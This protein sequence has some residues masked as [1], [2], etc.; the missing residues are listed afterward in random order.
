MARSLQAGWVFLRTAWCLAVIPPVLLGYCLA[1][2]AFA[3]VRAPQRAVDWLYHGFTG[4]SIWAGGTRLI[5]RGLEHLEPGQAYVIVPNHESGW[6]PIALVAA[7]PNSV[8]FL[9]K[10]EL[11]KIPIFGAALLSTGN[12]KVE[13]TNTQADVE[14]IRAR[15]AKRPLEA[16]VLVY[17]EG[18]RSRDG[19]LH[20]F[21][22]GA[23][24]T[25]ISYGLPVLPVGHA[26]C[27][28]IWP[29]ERLRVEKGP[30]WIEIG[31]PIPVDGLRHED[32]EKLRQET[33]EAVRTLRARARSRLREMGIEPGGID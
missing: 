24:A 16:S 13:R 19:G 7:L 23:F 2:I 5:V 30:V 11:I 32:R 22:K 1:A 8:R 28:R 26:G 10:S 17:A 29:P 33:F 25:A 12:V 21:K 18:T 4:F 27:R 14:R 9:V 31:R 20:E 3:A 6:D 15:M